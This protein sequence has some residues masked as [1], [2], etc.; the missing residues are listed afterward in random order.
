MWNQGT[1]RSLR[2]VCRRQ[3][4]IPGLQTVVHSMSARMTMDPD[5]PMGISVKNTPIQHRTW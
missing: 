1:D 3:E 4:D 2:S 5:A